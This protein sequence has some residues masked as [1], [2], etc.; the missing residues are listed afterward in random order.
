MRLPSFSVLVL[1][2]CLGSGLML[3]C[4]SST[5]SAPSATEEPPP[6]EAAPSHPASILVD[7][8][9][10]DWDAVPLRHTD[11]EGDGEALDLGT[12]KVAH[13]AERLYLRLD[14]GTAINLQEGN[15]LT[16]H[17][18]T[19]ADASTGASRRGLGAE[20]SWTFGERDG[21]VRTASGTTSIRHDALG[22]ATLPTV[23]SRVFEIA[24]DRSATPGGTP[25]FPSDS[26]RL[27]FTG[28]GDLLPDASGGL[29]YAFSET[30]LPD[31]PAPTLDRADGAVRLVSYNAERDAFLDDADR[32]GAYQRLLRALDADV[33]GF[34][35]LYDSRAEA[36]RQH[37]AALMD[38]GSTWY[39]EKTGLD[40]VLVSRYPIDATH[41]IAGYD[42]YASGAYLL[43]ATDALG[44]PLL[45]VLAHPPCCN[46][47]DATP[48]RDEQRQITVD[49]IAAFLRDVQAGSAP[50]DVP[51]GTP[52]VVAGDMNFVGSAQQPET[53]RT[54]EI[55]NT[56]RFG[57]SGAPDWDGSP[58]LDVNPRQTGTS[59]HATW[60]GTGSSFPPGRLDYIYTA[61]SATRVSNAFTLRTPTLPESVLAAHGLQADD[62]TV[63]SDHLPLVV[64][65]LP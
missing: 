60:M 65:L 9:S 45:V 28:G 38:G 17:L 63:A 27:A 39:A 49:A 12:L 61:D 8:G 18:D 64:D 40:L 3:G 57:S 37:V 22:L 16:L 19:D 62:T 31:R 52:I 56:D 44:T 10:G 1:L 35:E 26:I 7:G 14:V 32:E 33:I 2:G 15:T 58:L 30:T 25:L 43:D 48:S 29:A 54:G 50:I 20:V 21:E 23:R 11:P 46:Y 51:D 24:L 53:V 6:T 13:D 59:L 42:D 36:T 34:Q 47:G 5:D 41:T 4:S 55:V